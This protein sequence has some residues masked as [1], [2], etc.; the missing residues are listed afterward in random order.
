MKLIYKFENKILSPVDSLH[1]F[2]D[3][4]MDW[5]MRWKMPGVLPTELEPFWTCCSHSS[6]ILYPPL[7]RIPNFLHV[8]KRKN[9]G[10]SG[11]MNDLARIPVPAALSIAQCRQ[12]QGTSLQRNWSGLQ[13]HARTVITGF[14]EY[15]AGQHP[16]PWQTVS[17][18]NATECMRQ[19]L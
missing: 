5:R 3:S 12:S 13:Q 17:A 6:A 1:N 10:D 7:K 9:Q 19:N 4:C 18:S 16:V 8:P 2:N 11:L 15:A 14:V